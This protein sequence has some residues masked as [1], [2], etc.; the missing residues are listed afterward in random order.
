MAVRTATRRRASSGRNDPELADSTWPA[1]EPE[2]ITDDEDSYSNGPRQRFPVSERAEELSRRAMAFGAGHW[3]ED[4]VSPAKG[5]ESVAQPSVS[6]VPIALR[7][8][9][10]QADVG[11]GSSHRACSETMAPVLPEP[12][13]TSTPDRPIPTLPAVKRRRHKHKR[14]CYTCRQEGHESRVCPWR[15]KLCRGTGHGERDCP[16][17]VLVRAEAERTPWDHPRIHSESRRSGEKDRRR[18]VKAADVFQDLR[19]WLRR[20]MEDSPGNVTTGRSRDRWPSTAP[21]SR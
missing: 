17:M 16:L 3:L 1:D 18:P 5:G 13:G 7:E 11:F 2:S 8:P 19:R 12:S 9:E 14:R 6:D 20:R 4:A 15:C 21:A 10:A